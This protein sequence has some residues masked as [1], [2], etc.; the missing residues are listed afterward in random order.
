MVRHTCWTPGRVLHESVPPGGLH[1]A[2]LR[3]ALHAL[4]RHFNVADTEIAEGVVG[5]ARLQHLTA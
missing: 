5:T 3:A 4:T 2:R 1:P